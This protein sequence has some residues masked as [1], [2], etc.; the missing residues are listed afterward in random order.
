MADASNRVKGLVIQAEDARILGD[1]ALMRRIYADLYTLNRQLVTEYVKRA[2]NHQA[3]LNSLKEVN[4]MI[5]KAS[6]LRMGSAKSRVVSECRN[7]I[8]VNNIKSLFQIIKEGHDPRGANSTSGGGGGT[9]GGSSPVP[10]GG[11]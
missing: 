3:L 10:V 2:N 11:S 8:K 1:M 6:N 9:S 4:H 5:Q 7:A